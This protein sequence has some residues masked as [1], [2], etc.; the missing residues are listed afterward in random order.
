MVVQNISLDG[1]KTDLTFTVKAEDVKKTQKLIKENKNI[2]FKK[3]SL[4]KI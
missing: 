3:M 2:S 1:R 4:P